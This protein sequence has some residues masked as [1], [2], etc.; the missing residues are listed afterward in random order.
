M[1]GHG[2]PYLNNLSKDELSVEYTIR[3]I[4]STDRDASDQ[5]TAALH[6]EAVDD[7]LVVNAS[8]IVALPEVE[9]DLA[10]AVCDNLEASFPL[11]S[12]PIE[13]LQE[14]YYRSLHWIR[15]LRR[16][17]YSFGDA[18]NITNLTI[19]FKR[20]GL[21]AKTKMEDHLVHISVSQ[22]SEILNQSTA[23]DTTSTSSQTKTAVDVHTNTMPQTV[24]F[25]RIS[26]INSNVTWSNLKS[27][28]KENQ[29]IM[30]EN[31]GPEDNFQ[32]P[33]IECTSKK[34]PEKHHNEIESF[35][36]HTLSTFSTKMENIV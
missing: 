22:E 28:P 33:T 10:H 34:I 20:V 35:S 1:D 25:S 21:N 23:Q 12:S 16:L 15:R 9:L 31:I 29:N 26:P 32:L 18:V 17:K 14:I 4:K 11:D 2:Y 7:R 5:L 6:R 30:I 3:K 24:S 8:H 36:V 27:N 19:K 13:I